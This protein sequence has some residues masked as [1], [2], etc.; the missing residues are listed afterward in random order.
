[1]HREMFKSLIAAR[2]IYANK[3]SS[4]NSGRIEA[5]KIL[6]SAEYCTYINAAI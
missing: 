1:M 2:P 6:K 4:S 5:L 3:Y